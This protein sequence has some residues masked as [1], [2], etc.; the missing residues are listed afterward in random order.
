[1]AN[2]QPVSY[3]C[4]RLQKTATKPTPNSDVYVID[5]VTT[6]TWTPLYL[7][8]MFIEGSL[9]RQEKKMDWIDQVQVDII[10]WWDFR[11]S[12]LKYKD[13]RSPKP[14]EVISETE[15]PA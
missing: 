11:T 5:W 14:K 13:M 2:L 4:E 15:T 3:F 6:Q 7:H 1:M 9:D 8:K 12:V 10:N